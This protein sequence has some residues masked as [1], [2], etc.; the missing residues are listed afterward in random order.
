MLKIESFLNLRIKIQI[1]YRILNLLIQA[2]PFTFYIELI[3]HWLISILL[4]WLQLKKVILCL[5]LLSLS[6]KILSRIIKFLVHLLQEWRLVIIIFLRRRAHMKRIEVNLIIV[7]GL[8]LLIFR[9]FHQLHNTWN[10]IENILAQRG[11]LFTLFRLFLIAWNLKFLLIYYILE[12]Q[13]F[14]DF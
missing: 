10:V 9:S 11:H 2:L 1:L 7:R 12:V 8:F 5:E 3:I 4:L 14:Y 6:L 13:W